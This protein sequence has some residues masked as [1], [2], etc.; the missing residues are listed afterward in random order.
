[1]KRK[2]ILSVC[3]LVGLFLYIFSVSAICAENKPQ[4]TNE[5]ILKYLNNQITLYP[6]EKAGYF[7]RG[8]HYRENK[9]WGKAINDYSKALKLADPN[10]SLLTY[11]NRGAC[12]QMLYMYDEAIKDYSEVLK[13]GNIQLND[14]DYY[15]NK[16]GTWGQKIR[17]G[18]KETMSKAYNNRGIVFENLGN[19]QQ[20]LK[21]FGDS[22]RILLQEN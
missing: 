3:V 16:F 12:Y 8:Q 6:E 11:L 13:I 15:K 18:V 10:D 17:E 2:N 19:K 4:V 9:E 7:N 14:K 22:S 5:Q 1:M 20:A 21:D